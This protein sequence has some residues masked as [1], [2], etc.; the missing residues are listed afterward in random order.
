MSDDAPSAATTAVATDADAGV[1]VGVGRGGTHIL[2]VGD[3]F[4]DVAAG[5]LSEMPPWGHAVVSPDPIR[6]LPGGCALNVASS[7]SRLCSG[8]TAA[9][10]SGIGNDAFGAIPRRH[11]NQLG[12]QL[13]AAS[14]DDP[15][16]PTGVCMVVSGPHD[17]SLIFHSGIADRFDAKGLPRERLQAMCAAGLRHLHVSGFYSCAALRQD[18]PRLLRDARACG[19]TTSLDPNHDPTG[20]WA[21]VDGLWD[22]ILPLLDVL[23][24]NELEALALADTAPT[25]AT[26]AASDEA[27]AS[28]ATVTSADGGSDGGASAALL[29]GAND[30]AARLEAAVELLAAQTGGGCVVVTTGSAGKLL[31]G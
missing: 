25:P 30:A 18:L 12:V 2:V 26:V 8:R 23:L 28:A 4:V 1:G 21:R 5:P 10:Y 11:L 9:L 27:A 24:P 13:H 31:L 17:R 29:P 7:L 20:E 14:C 16:A 15:D 6:A 3:T 19:L 22:E